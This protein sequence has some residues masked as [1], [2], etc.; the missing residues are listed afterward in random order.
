MV[1]LGVLSALVVLCAAPAHID[2]APLQGFTV[3][4]IDEETALEETLPRAEEGDCDAIGRLV[5]MYTNG[6]G[7][8]KDL[9]AA[10]MWADILAELGDEGSRYARDAIARNMT[11]SETA[12]ARR[13]AEAWIQGRPGLAAP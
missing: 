8:S 13:L 10:Y 6:V 3:E 4:W 11:L 7:V 5:F 12:E 1:S 2:E 9:V